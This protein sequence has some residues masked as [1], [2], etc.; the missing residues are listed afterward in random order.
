MSEMKY[1]MLAEIYGRMEAELI[2][3]YLEA[4]EIDVELFQESV[5]QNIYPTTIDQLGKVQVFV[6]RE[7]LEE[8]RIL[9]KEM[10]Q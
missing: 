1:E 9:L 2:K 6:K 3:S 4:N 5:G 10:E 7:N 8:A